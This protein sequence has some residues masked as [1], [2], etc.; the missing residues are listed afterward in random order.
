LRA[1]FFGSGAARTDS[2]VERLAKH[3]RNVKRIEAMEQENARHE[4]R[5][6]SWYVD[7]DGSFGVR[8]RLTPEHGDRVAKAI[9]AV[10]DENG[11]DSKNVSAETFSGASWF[12]G[13]SVLCLWSGMES[14]CIAAEVR[15]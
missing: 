12:P 4:L 6:L 2:H 14:L 5:E 13:V 15:R 1:R 3:Y 9:E 10:C 8:A 7:D 11:C